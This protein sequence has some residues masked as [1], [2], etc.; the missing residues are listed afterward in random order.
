MKTGLKASSITLALIGLAA[1]GVQPVLVSMLIEVAHFSDSGAGYIASADVF[2]IAATNAA[3]TL[4]G[5]RWN[6]RKLCVAGLLLMIAGNLASIFSGADAGSLMLSRFASGLGS[7]LLISRGYAAAGLARNPGRMFGYILAVST[8]QVAAA[9]FLLP[10]WSAT[11]GVNV[12]FQYFVVLAVIGCL[13]VRWMP[14]GGAAQPSVGRA[15]AASMAECA[16]A[17]GSAA[18]LFLGLGILWPYL[19]QIGISAGIGAESAAIGLSV[20]QLAAF[21][22]AL[23]AAFG[24]RWLPAASLL[25]AGLVVTIASTLLFQTA[26]TGLGYGL[27]ASGFNGASNTAMV[28]VMGAVAAADSDGRLIAAAVTAQT[29]GF[30]LGPALAAAVVTDGSY[31]VAQVLSAVVVATSLVAALTVM[32]MRRARL[33]TSA[34][35]AAAPSRII[36]P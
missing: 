34:A 29:L 30:A 22:G 3:T 8:A 25:I 31:L 7:G 16:F 5:H 27:M 18:T 9:S 4:A 24:V 14:A 32:L 10:R 20:S 1:L 26:T 11:G 19:M 33:T 35:Q 21:A 36:T 17:L 23:V 28:L 13:F 15:G 2:G 6:W 12:V